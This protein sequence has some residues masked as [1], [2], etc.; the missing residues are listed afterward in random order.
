MDRL[1]PSLIEKK[2]RLLELLQEKQEYDD[3]HDSV[4]DVGSEMENSTVHAEEHLMF[5]VEGE[6]AK[7][8]SK[9][10]CFPSSFW[11]LSFKR[12]RKKKKD[13]KDK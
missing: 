13:Q 9:A 10:G 1:K 12:R 11:K 3:E 5:S 7:K 6:K 8:S 4:T 2:K